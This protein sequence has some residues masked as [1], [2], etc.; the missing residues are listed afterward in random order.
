[1]KRFVVTAL[2]ALLWSAAN[3]QTLLYNPSLGLPAT[4]GWLPL[5]VGTPGTQGIAGNLY[6]LDTTADI[7]TTHGNGRLSPVVLN[8]QTGFTLNFSLRV[9]AENHS[10]N[11]RAG[12]SMLF[13]GNDPTQSLELAFWNNEVFAYDYV[14]A[15]PDRFVHGSG[16]ALNTGLAQRSYSLQVA[17]QLYTLKADGNT[18]FSGSLAN[19]TAQGLP[20]TTP[21]F[22]FFG[23]NTSRGASIVEVGPIILSAVPELGS[24]SMMALGLAGLVVLRRAQRR[25]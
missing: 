15:D 18:L 6:Q 3:A 24:L 10:S 9:A 5:V 7:N 1:M 16:A 17:N 19:Y 2:G 25:D 14:A 12:F 21:N 11:N 8:T 20:Y 4:Q 22:L 13:V 23:D